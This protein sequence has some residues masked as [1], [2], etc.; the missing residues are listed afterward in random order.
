MDICTCQE[1]ILWRIIET[2]DMLNIAWHTYSHM[3]EYSMLFLTYHVFV[4]VSCDVYPGATSE[5]SCTSVTWLVSVSC[6]LSEMSCD[7][8]MSCD[9]CMWF[10]YN[11]S[12]DLY[13]WINCYIQSCVLFLNK[14]F[15]NIC[16]MWRVHSK[17]K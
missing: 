7:L 16:I 1:I 6:D 13:L 14:L 10:T 11:M 4:S 17:S 2:K 8:Y 3:F 9:L 12:C 5:M 15:K